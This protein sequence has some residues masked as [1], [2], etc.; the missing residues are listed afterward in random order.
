M[1]PAAEKFPKNYNSLKQIHS[2]GQP[3]MQEVNQSIQ[4]PIKLILV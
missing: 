1:S 3:F 4:Q 2:A